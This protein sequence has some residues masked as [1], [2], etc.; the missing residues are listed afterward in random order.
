MI[1]DDDD[2]DK[3]MKEL[4][5]EVSAPAPAPAA[6]KR[7][8]KT[9]T[10]VTDDKVNPEPALAAK[11]TDAAKEKVV[12]ENDGFIKIAGLPRTDAESVNVTVIENAPAKEPY[13]SP[14]TRAEME[15]GRA[16]LNRYK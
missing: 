6:P 12:E 8:R 5:A 3:M 15:A 11:L 7:G 13:I 9:Q 4:D 2:F 10:V 16:V 1:G 14:Q